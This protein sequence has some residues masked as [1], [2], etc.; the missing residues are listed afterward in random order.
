VV[1]RDAHYLS[2]SQ[3]AGTVIPSDHPSIYSHAA[4][5]GNY[6]RCLRLHNIREPE[7]ADN[8]RVDGH[9]NARPVVGKVPTK[10]AH[11]LHVMYAQRAEHMGDS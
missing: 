6:R 10:R 5:A 7:D 2:H 9:K 3:R 11:T 8:L 1:S 4:K